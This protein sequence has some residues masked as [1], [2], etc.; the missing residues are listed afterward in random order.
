MSSDHDPVRLGADPHSSPWLRSLLTEAHA[1][2]SDGLDID[3]L[4]ARVQAAILVDAPVP[5]GPPAHNAPLGKL[6]ASK[7]VWLG[8][9]VVV[10]M[11]VGTAW[12]LKKAP[13]SVPPPSAS[14]AQP[15]AL[16]RSKALIQEISSSPTASALGENNVAL[17]PAP[18]VSTNSPSASHDSRSVGLNEAALLDGARAALGTDPRRAL[19]LTQE[20]AKRFPH[21]TLI[22]ER[23][24][25]AIDA[26]SRLGQTDAARRRASDF[27]RRYPGSAHQPKVDQTTRGQ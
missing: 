3:R 17:Q 16:D 1:Q 26:L 8:A 11:S 22:Q 27:E 10:G 2:A 13:L 6:A 9:G 20:H 19:A 12:M 24:V 5:S 18:A 25:I 21:G 14:A 23:E 15:M 4:T 7:A